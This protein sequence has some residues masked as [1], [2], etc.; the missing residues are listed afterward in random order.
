MLQNKKA[1]SIISVAKI[2]K[3][4]RPTMLYHKLFQF[5]KIYIL[6]NINILAYI[7]K[8]NSIY[9]N[10]T[11]HKKPFSKLPYIN[12][13]FGVYNCKYFHPLFQHCK[14]IPKKTSYVQKNT[15][16]IYLY[17]QNSKNLETF[18]KKSFYL[19][20]NHFSMNKAK[21][22]AFIFDFYFFFIS[23]QWIYC[24]SKTF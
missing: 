8:I 16:N 15:F 11:F 13:S 6:L 10:K 20:L 14:I 4:L 5:F 1:L 9:K 18:K 22:I 2:N 3:T 17:I 24:I 7:T 23:L 19:F 12:Q 21:F